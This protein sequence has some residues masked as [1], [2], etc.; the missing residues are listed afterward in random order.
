[1][2]LQNE[3]RPMKAL[4]TV[5][6]IG[7]LVVLTSPAGT[8]TCLAED[9]YLIAPADTLE[10]SVYGEQDLVR[11]LIVRPDGKVSFPLVGDIEVSG[12]TTTQ[13]KA[14]V[15]KKVRDYVPDASVTV[16]VAGLGSLQYYVLGKVANPGAFNLSRP[17]TA[18]Q[19]L[20]TA[21]GVTTFAN[22]DDILI[23]RGHGND[24]THVP[25]NYGAVKNG[26]KLE[27]NILLERGDVVLVP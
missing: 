25:F 17:V 15:E 21:G 6:F 20:A 24:T 18:L 14:E 23:V 19:A 7:L 22:E 4:T 13:V 3:E 8:S 5:F 26:K 11:E 16:I 10:I 27:Q 2:R 9:L 1:M 12:K